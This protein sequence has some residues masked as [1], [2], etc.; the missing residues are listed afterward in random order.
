MPE[1][2]SFGEITFQVLSIL[3]PMLKAGLVIAGL[4]GWLGSSAQSYQF[5][6]GRE[7]YAS[8]SGN[9]GEIRPN[10]WHYGLD[11][12]AWYNTPVLAVADGSVVRVRVSSGG[13]G[14]SIYV[15]HAD[16]R[17]SLYGHL[18]K[19]TPQLEAA[20]AQLQAANEQFEQE[21]FA[22]VGQYPVQRGQ[23]IAY[24]G[25]TGNSGGPH[26]HYELRDTSELVLN[27]LGYHLDLVRDS[28]PPVLQRIA[29]EPLTYRSRVN[30]RFDKL[31]ASPQGSGLVYSSQEVV[32]DGPVGLEFTAYDLIDGSPNYSGLYRV[33]LKLDGL[34]VWEQRMDR[35][36]FHHSPS[37]NQHIDYSYYRNTRGVLQK[38]YHDSGNRTPVYPTLVKDGVLELFDALPHTAELTLQDYHGNKSIWR[39]KIRRSVSSGP[40][41]TDG[42]SLAP[43]FTVRR[44]VLV[45]KHGLPGLADTARVRVVYNDGSD[46]LLI[47]SYSYGGYAHTLLPMDDGRLPARANATW[48]PN[49]IFFNFLTHIN[50]NRPTTAR[51]NDKFWVDFPMGSL[52][53]PMPLTVTQFP[54][55]AEPLVLSPVYIVGNPDVALH[56]SCYLNLQFV[57][58]EKSIK[59][60]AEQ[61][62]VARRILPGRYER[63]T[64]DHHI[65]RQYVAPTRTFGEFC[66]VA[67]IDP[68]SI[69][70][71][72][73]ADRGTVKAGDLLQASLR[74]ELAG[75]HPQKIR[76]LWD[77]R[78]LLPEYY[79]YSSLVQMRVPT[80]KGTHQLVLEVT[81]FAGNTTRRSYSL[82]VS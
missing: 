15:L 21:L 51:L 66:L 53:L 31:I 41:I 80:G 63:V 40:M 55:P 16:G 24:S 2:T 3:P 52:F 79:S 45:L 42:S 35:F 69:A 49:A 54:V 73:F 58:T 50:P 70:P 9:F 27:P 65:G 68:P 19:F 71:K 64:G 14:K 32:V 29:W 38:A 57:P 47:P 44:N 82:N 28:R 23:V 46:T 74:D 22:E 11:I 10:H 4:L 26:L 12:R 30:G 33:Q 37:I 48:W 60:R 59:Y 20:I 36:G 43:S 72:N 34:L 13:Y 1:V 6:I 39:G 81:D 78:W 17:M 61:I 8:L 7:N 77:G 25:S 76:A 62:V 56:S 75:V 18:T 5:P 67:D